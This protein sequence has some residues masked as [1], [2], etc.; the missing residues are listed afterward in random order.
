M[1]PTSSPV[2]FPNAYRGQ[3]CRVLT[4]EL[5]AC[6]TVSR[7]PG[8]WSHPEHWGERSEDTW[9]LCRMSELR[10][11]GLVPHF[12]DGETEAHRGGRTS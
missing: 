12:T 3:Q 10:G 4:S 6:S 9:S 1:E 8:L 11:T 7:P 5:S 2:R